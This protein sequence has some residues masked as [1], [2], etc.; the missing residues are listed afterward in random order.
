MNTSQKSEALRLAHKYEVEGFLG[1]HKFAQNKW[2]SDAATEL[3]RQ[4]TRIEELE[5]QLEAI[6]AGGVEPLRKS[7]SVAASERELFEAVASD[8]GKWPKAIERDA[9]G[10]YL[11]LTTANGWMW[12]REARSLLAEVPAPAIQA[13]P[14]A[15]LHTSKRG[16]VQA[17]TAEPPP[18][19]KAQCQPLYSEQQ[20]RALLAEAS[21]P[22]VLGT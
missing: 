2:C 10:N 13:E 9:K 5:A 12:W 4:H 7:A 8:N 18:S 15:W 22:V 21:T 1:E 14:V 17:F 11:L 19:L 16:G 6:R 3:R 20:V